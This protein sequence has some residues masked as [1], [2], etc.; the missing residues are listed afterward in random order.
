MFS[1]SLSGTRNASPIVVLGDKNLVDIGS[2]SDAVYTNG[3]ASAGQE[4]DENRRLL[5]LA[6]YMS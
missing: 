3:I 4:E 2:W 1:Y 5:V 6:I